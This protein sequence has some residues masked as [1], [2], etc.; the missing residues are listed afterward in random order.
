MSLEKLINKNKWNKIYNLLKNN[1]I[2]PTEEISNGNTIIHLAAINNNNK[3]ISYFL[4]INKSILKKSNNEGNSIFHLLALYG[5]IDLLKK[6]IIKI[7][8]LL[9]L[10]NNNNENIYN[11][12]YKNFDFI[13]WI[14][15]YKKYKK[16][17]I[18]IDDIHG[19]NIITKNINES[20]SIKDI[21]YKIIKLLIITY[22]EQI[23]SYQDSLLCYSIFKYKY[24]IAKLLLKY[25][26]DV[27]KKDIKYNTP[28]IYAINNKNYKLAKYLIQK[29]ADI[30]Y[31]G[32]NGNSNPMILS[33]N[34]KNDKIIDL[35][36]DNGFDVNNY[37][38]YIE[39]PLHYAL[40]KNNKLSPTIIFKLLYYG[41]LNIQNIDGETPLHLLCKYHNFRNY[42]KVIENK[43]L[44]IFIKDKMN[45]KPIDYINSNHIYEFIKIVL[46]SYIKQ[47]NGQINNIDEC[48]KNSSSTLCKNELKKHIFKT[49]RSIPISDDQKIIYKKFKM[50]QGYVTNY[51]IF[52]T[53]I[54]HNIIYTIIILKKYDNIGIPF[55]YY[56]TDK[57]IN[58]RITYSNNDLYY[59]DIETM[60]SDI[61][62]IYLNYFYEIIPHLIIWKNSAQYYIHHDLKFH[63]LKCMQGNK[64]RF[65]FLKL[66]LVVVS[67]NTHANIIIYDKVNNTL[68]RFEPYGVIPYLENEKLDIFLI[69]FGKEYFDINT[70][71]YS[72]KDIFGNI[73]FQSISND[74]E[75]YVRKLG[76]PIGFCLGWCFWYLEMKVNNPDIKP[77]IFIKQA[78][79]Q[80]IDQN[81]DSDKTFISFIRNYASDLDRQKNNFMKL[82]G[83]NKNNIYDLVLSQNDHNNI[84]KNLIFE[85]N[86]IIQ[87]RY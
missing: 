38:K 63:L 78:M 72:P 80:I 55:Q 67:S 37:N 33:I 54:L 75:Q 87:N 83:I 36:L 60:I 73:G 77:F 53:D 19:Q 8:D 56:I 64:I 14:I 70:K 6:C 68:E 15:K 22:T 25:N 62:K 59:G 20:I 17:K 4:D 7:P 26:Y 2:D 24:H 31:N 74:N 50:I 86:K 44:D 51:G 11:L 47:I 34:N 28:F 76:D 52:N 46:N 45:K 5:Y 3:I 13:D 48:R 32:I 18:L 71:Y 42:N 39:T 43:K 79:H 69:N 23:K 41:D 30:N 49:K 61:V 21:N 66:T 35:L 29:G 65:I 40:Y 1:K 85:F 16:Y 84:F 58:D 81:V 27:N 12:L 9:N 10:L 82:A 57:Y